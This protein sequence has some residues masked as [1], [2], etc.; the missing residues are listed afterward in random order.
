VDRMI[1]KTW[2]V[3][4]TGVDVVDR[5]EPLRLALDESEAQWSTTSTRSPLVHSSYQ[6]RRR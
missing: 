3:K 6:R 1:A 5:V 2:S 4:W